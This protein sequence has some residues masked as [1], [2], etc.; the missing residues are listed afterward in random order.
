MPATSIGLDDVLDVSFLDSEDSVDPAAN[1]SG[2]RHLRNLCRWDRVPMG[3]FRRSRTA[4]TEGLNIRVSRLAPPNDGVS[5]GSAGGH[6]LRKSPLGAALW[7]TNDEKVTSK[8]P[9]GSVTVSPVIFPVRDGVH[10]PITNQYPDPLQEPEP[11]K[12]GPSK[13]RK[14]KHKERKGRT[15]PLRSSPASIPMP[16]GFHHPLPIVPSL[17]L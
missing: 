10:I 16:S 11:S 12:P 13:S 1:T 2:E 4:H 7:Q 15:L 3:T 6:V 5:Y 9:P 8:H 14:Q 17:K